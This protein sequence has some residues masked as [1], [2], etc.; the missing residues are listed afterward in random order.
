M[1]LTEL[2]Y[3]VTLAQERHFGRAAERCFVSQPTL[4][5]AVKKLEEELGVAL[6]ERSKSTVQVTPLGERIV[7]QASRVLEQ[8]GAIK[9]LANEGKDQLSSP[10]RVGAIH[11]IGPYLF[12]H[13]IP[14]LSEEAPQMPLY[15]EENLTGELRR[16]LRS[17][18]LD[19]IIVAL[20]FAEPDV[21]TKSLYDEPF[22]VLLPAGHAWLSRK[23]IDRDVLYDEKMLMLGEGHCFRD[24]VLEACP[25]IKNHVHQPGNTLIAEGGSL[26]TIRHMVASGL[27]IT[28][29]P[30]SATGSV[31]YAS[32]LLE[33][34]PFRDP[35][36]YRTVALAWRASFPRPKAIDSI[37]RAIKAC[38]KAINPE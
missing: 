24:Q 17:G 31:H 1:T 6:F 19:V 8:A 38:H 33:T 15:I 4:S 27:G 13:L 29:V 35:A 5:V 32:G 21:L 23:E 11:T 16:K 28:V 34:R 20:P 37:T 36:P 3:I 10:L 12:P 14:R 22:E 25:T 30:Q 7:E 26:E 2:R 18:E 9:E